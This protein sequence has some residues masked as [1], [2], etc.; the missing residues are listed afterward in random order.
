MTD[1]N[2]SLAK[3]RDLLASETAL[4][5]VPETSAGRRLD[6]F[7]AE[8][9]AV[10][11]TRIQRV[12][13]D[14]EVRVNG[15]VRRASYRVE[16]GDEIEGDVPA[17][18]TTDL[19]PEDLPLS[20]QFEDASILVL[21]KP[22][23]QVVHPAAGVTRGTLANALAFHF[24]RRQPG[25]DTLRPGIVHR[26]DRDTS[27]L[28]VVAKTDAALEHLAEQ[29]RART[30]E[31]GYVALVHGDLVGAGTIDVPIA[32]DRKHRLKMTVTPNGRPARS[33]Y[34]VRRR[35]GPVTLLDVRI[36]TGRTHQIRV[37]CAHIRHPVVGD[38]LYGLGRDRQL[39]HP[40]QCQ[41]VEQL[42][43]QFLH[44]AHLAFVH[45]VS[46]QPMRFF[47]PLPPDLQ[48]CLQTFAGS[49]AG[50]CLSGLLLPTTC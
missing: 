20:I 30:V 25:G 1:A 24:G 45:P 18:V 46:A 8:F 5:R 23:G 19:T 40:A 15:Q 28:M 39:R 32:R 50:E 10:S 16:P 22:A 41:A 11:R 4:C 35:F 29:F 7:L 38:P 2:T 9:L 31:K 17:P 36:E 27:G 26:L 34:V 47:S 43:R 6:V 14:G 33:H 3:A 37:H 42:G 44:A 48:A 12:L 21:D 49:D 13:A